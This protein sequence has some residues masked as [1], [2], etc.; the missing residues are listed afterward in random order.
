MNTFT[1]QDMED[2]A[3][4]VVKAKTV[5]VEPTLSHWYAQRNKPTKKVTCFEVIDHTAEVVGSNFKEFGIPDMGRV[6]VKYDVNVELSYQDDG[7]MLKVF[8]KDKES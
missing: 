1:E 3:D 6:L 5:Q 2:Y 8:L 4:Y 7:K